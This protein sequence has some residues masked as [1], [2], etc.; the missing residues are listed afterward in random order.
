MK[1]L[2]VEL[3]DP[4]SRALIQDYSAGKLK[5]LELSLDKKQKL[6]AKKLEV[7]EKSSDADTIKV[8][9]GA[10]KDQEDPRYI[11]FTYP[12]SKGEKKVFLYY[13]P[14]NAERTL[15]FTYSTCKGVITTALEAAGV[16]ID[17]KMEEAPR[18]DGE[19]DVT[20]QS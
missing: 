9:F 17:G 18:A 20:V 14:E 5:A 7:E 11:I 15:K 19:P 12:H 3:K 4:A 8:V 6:S 13:C 10:I 2:P 1:P 16:K